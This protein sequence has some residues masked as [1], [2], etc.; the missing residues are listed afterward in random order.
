MDEQ[1]QRPA[2]GST[3]PDGDASA[4]GPGPEFGPGGYLPERASRRARKIVLRA[5]LGLQWIVGS[6]VVAV[7]VA[8]AGGVMLR[9]QPPQAPYVHL[10]GLDPTMQ[11]ARVLG[12][13][14]FDGA[15]L[16]VGVGRPRVFALPTDQS[17]TYCAESGLLEGSDGEAWRL[18]GRGVGGTPSLA[19]HP[20]VLFDGELWVDPTTTL[21]PPATDPAD[22]SLACSAAG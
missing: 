3:A 7:V 16:F 15:A 2:D 22:V 21:A 13:A 8:V 18:T 5:P 14:P 9:E 12:G 6:L 4:P 11:E 17:V 19:E 20:T 10:R 1:P